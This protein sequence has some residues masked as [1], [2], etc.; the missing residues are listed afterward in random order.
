MHIDFAENQLSR[1][2]HVNYGHSCATAP[3]WQLKSIIIWQQGPFSMC[4]FHSFNV[5]VLRGQ[6]GLKE[7][8]FMQKKKKKKLEENTMKLII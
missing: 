2:P 8:Y 4:P 3:Q 6:L 7:G 5:C 1:I